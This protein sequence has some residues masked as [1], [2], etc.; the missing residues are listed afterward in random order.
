[1]AKAAR[2]IIVTRDLDKDPTQAALLARYGPAAGAVSARVVGAITGSLTRVPN[3]AGESTLGDV[4]ADALLE[5]ANRT[6][7]AEADLAIW[8]PGG[9]RA[10]LEMKRDA[11]PT[12]VTFA[13]VFAVLP[14][15]NELI[16]KSVTAESLL[17]MLEQQFGGPDGASDR[18]RIM[19][20]SKGFT[21]AYD[22]SR[23]FGQRID[24]A[25]VRLNGEPL[26]PDR[27]YRLATSNFLW[28]GGDGLVALSA[29]TDAVLVGVDH[30]ILAEH[31]ARD[32]PVPP[33]PQNRIHRIR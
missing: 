4:V 28:G 6:Q 22:E 17:Q 20:V 2:N 23:P 25:S 32:S 21:Y 1:V 31:F 13:E 30:D 19:Q 27:R 26:A 16:V 8:N 3:T 14:F 18:V 9:I 12:P 10:D 15:G 29:G 7:G 11:R 33:G 24:R 5:A